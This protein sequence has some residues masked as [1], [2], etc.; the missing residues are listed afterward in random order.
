MAQQGKAEFEKLSASDRKK[1]FAAINT[2]L[3]DSLEA[4][5]QQLKLMPY[6]AVSE[7]PRTPL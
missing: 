5:W 7:R 2:Q 4:A 6:Q 3:A 1:I